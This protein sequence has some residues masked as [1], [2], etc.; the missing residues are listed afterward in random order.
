MEVVIQMELFPSASEQDLKIAKRLVYR[1][2][3]MRKTSDELLQK[4]DLT[5]KEKQVA[6]EYKRKAD[7]VEMAIRMITE[8][9][10]R[11][12]MEHRFIKGFPRSGTVIRFK[13]ITD[14]SVDRRILKGIKCV[15]ETLKLIDII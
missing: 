4:E 6:K 15:A 1:Y 2:S 10:V 5:E 8:D 12:V 7:A 3:R 13:G 9:P 14:R 11:A